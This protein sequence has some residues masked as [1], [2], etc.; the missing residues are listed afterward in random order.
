MAASSEAITALIHAAEN[1][2]L[3]D[4]AIAKYGEYELNGRKYNFLHNF[5][6][7]YTI[8]ETIGSG[9]SGTVTL[10]RDRRHERSVAIKFITPLPL[11]LP[12]LASE[13][14]VLSE[15]KEISSVP[16]LVEAFVLRS[17]LEVRAAINKNRTVPI[18]MKAHPFDVAI[19]MDFV[20]GPSVRQSIDELLK[21]ETRAEFDFGVVANFAYWL[22]STLEKLHS[23]DI[24]HRDI[25]PDNIIMSENQFFLVD[26]G[27]AC[28]TDL[29]TEYHCRRFDIGSPLYLELNVLK[30]GKTTIEHVKGNDVW[31]AAVT[32]YEFCH[33]DMMFSGNDLDEYIDFIEDH[34]LI[35]DEDEW[36]ALGQIM[37]DALTLDQDQ[38]PTA[39]A[40]RERLESV[41]IPHLL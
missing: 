33:P 40:M 9:T 22:F 39:K 6:D 31:S 16:N 20:D 7:V 19:V 37:N 38:R 8:E 29:K 27:F 3:H 18:S 25:K 12:Y 35:F 15:L 4:D 2:K 24:V 17:P 28:S 11:T 34:N 23:R 14:A 21:L 13:I 5:S 26:F 30:T 32:I 10:A 1:I 41:I 36:G